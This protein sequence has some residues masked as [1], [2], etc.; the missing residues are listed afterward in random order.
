M[1]SK[2][3]VDNLVKK[4]EFNYIFDFVNNPDNFRARLD[5][6]RYEVLKIK[7]NNGEGTW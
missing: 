3:W 6:L 5:R 1:T 4:D 7:P 2:A